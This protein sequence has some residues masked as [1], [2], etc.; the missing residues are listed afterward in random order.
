M[1]HLKLVKT[2]RLTVKSLP[3]S[4][5]HKPHLRWFRAYT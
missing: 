2:I 4:G 5:I 3:M 1:E